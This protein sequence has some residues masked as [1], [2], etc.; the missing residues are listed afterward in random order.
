MVIEEACDIGFIGAVGCRGQAQEE[1]RRKRMEDSPVACRGGV[2][3]LVEDDVVE[4]I[5]REAFQRRG[6]R[7]LLDRGEHHIPGEIRSGADA[8][9]E[10][11]VGKD[12]AERRRSLREQLAA[13]REEQDLWAPVE[14][15]GERCDVEC[16]EERLAQACREHDQRALFPSLACGH[17]GRERL[18]LHV[19]RLG[20]RASVVL[21]LAQWQRP[22]VPARSDSVFIQPPLVQ[23]AAQFAHLGRGQSH[24]FPRMRIEAPFD[25][26]VPLD[27]ILQRRARQVGTANVGDAVDRVSA[28]P[29]HPGLGVERALQPFGLD[30]PNLKGARQGFCLKVFA[31]RIGRCAALQ[32][33]QP[34]Q[35]VGLGDVEVVARDERQPAA[36]AEK[37][38]ERRLQQV[39]A[40]VL[41]KG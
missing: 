33:E 9:R 7:D 10:P 34:L 23:R 31:L 22:L 41:H 2:M 5:F 18:G 37:L 28:P 30:H 29:E 12:F 25:A 39:Q 19:A 20:S 36:V 21:H 40:G 27:A 4:P 11:G 15:F 14:R 17:Q 38:L 6:T 13:M 8:P 24:S 35:R 16:R 32:V 3:H 1:V 26:Q